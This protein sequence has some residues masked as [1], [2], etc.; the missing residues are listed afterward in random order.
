MARNT[1]AK[2]QILKFIQGSNQAVSHADI[3][4]ALQ[5]LCDRVTIYRVLDRLVNENKIHKI[6]NVDG[7]INYATCHSC[8]TIHYHNHLHFSCENCKSITCLD[9]H[10]ISF[11]LPPNYQFK[12]SFFTI[13]G[14]CPNCN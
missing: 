8:T 2:Q 4:A 6:V 14:V 5:S 9:E 3:Y 10:E 1:Q 12:E 11:S 13:S 7:V